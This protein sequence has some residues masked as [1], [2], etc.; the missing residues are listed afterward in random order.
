MRSFRLLFGL[1][2][3]GIHAAPTFSG[4]LFG[5]GFASRRLYTINTQNGVREIQ[6]LLT[7]FPQ[8]P[9][10]NGLAYNSSNGT[11][12]ATSFNRLPGIPARERKWGMLEIDPITLSSTVIK[13]SYPQNY[14]VVDGLEYDPLRDV[15]WGTV[16][17][18]RQLVRIDLNTATLEVAAIF[19]PGSLISGLAF[20]PSTA[21]LYGVNDDG[22][23]DDSL[24]SLVKINIAT[25]SLTT[26]GE[27]G[28]GLGLY[29][30][31]SLAFDP[32]AR[33]LYTINDG[34]RSNRGLWQQLVRID[35]LTG[36]AELVGPHEVG[37]T[38]FYQGLA[39]IVPEPDTIA[40]LVI[41][42]ICVAARRRRHGAAIAK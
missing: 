14:P 21:T 19:P 36:Q 23:S 34:N 13:I 40:S 15:L 29:D 18:E 28:L 33:W 3:L 31:D 7:G 24:S 1:I 37:L 42:S 38:E 35:P 32:L 41:V 39:F 26:V 20:D 8:A 16:P 12:Y 27:P 17:I 30:L 5:G 11:L 4:Q 22:S 6:P 25:G 2:L 9:D 10:F